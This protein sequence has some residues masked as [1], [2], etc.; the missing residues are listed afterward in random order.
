MYG[1][2]IV[3]GTAMVDPWELGIPR[4]CDPVNAI[5]KAASDLMIVY[6]NVTVLLTWNGPSSSL[7]IHPQ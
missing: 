5:V 6:V 1:A 4:G 7:S 2:V 3:N